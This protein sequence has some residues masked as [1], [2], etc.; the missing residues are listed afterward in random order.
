M[1][2]SPRL[3]DYQRK[4][5]RRLSTSKPMTARQ[6]AE[7][8]GGRGRGYAAMTLILLEERGVAAEVPADSGR[9]VRGPNWVATATYY[10]WPTGRE[11]D[12]GRMPSPDKEDDYG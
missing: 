2:N 4:I 12:F 1:D 8:I 10:Q 5:A 9:F 6:A 3:G 11:E 7:F